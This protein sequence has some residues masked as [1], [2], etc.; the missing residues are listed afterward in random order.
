MF[1]FFSKLLPP[2]VYPLGL[3]VLLVAGGLLLHR[4]PRLQRWALIAALAL[5]FVAGNRWTAMGLARS[6][7]NRYRP[8]AVLPRGEVIVVLGGGTEAQDPP[9]PM[10]EVNGAGD[11][12]IYAASLYRQGAAKQILVSGGRLDWSAL[13]TTPADEMAALLVFMGVPES[14]IWR[15]AESCNTYEDAKFSAGL[16]REQGIGRALLVTSAF[17]MPRAVRLFEAQGIEVV[18]LPVDYTVTDSEWQGLASPDWRSAALSIFPSVE[19]LSLTTKILKEYLGI[20][21]YDLRGWD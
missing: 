3:A 11:R 20:L 21:V 4:R 7:E 1:V 6:L 8:P 12:V 10:A 19:N 18:P 5:L 17:H 14:A 2:L 16:L 9:R 15:Q 13:T